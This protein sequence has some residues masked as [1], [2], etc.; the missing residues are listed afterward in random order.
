MVTLQ[1]PAR[2]CFFGDHQ[3]YLGLPVIAGTIDRFIQL[4]AVPN[5]THNFIIAL[6]DINNTVT[7]ALDESLE[8]IKEGDYF[9][10]AMAV[11]KEYGFRFNQG[12]T[13]TIRGNIPINAG[14]SS[15]SALTV[16]WIRFLIASQEGIKQVNDEEIGRWAYSAEV[17]YF[18]QPGGLMDH[19]T[20]AQRGLLYI[21]TQTGSTERLKNRLGQLV[22]AESGIPKRTLSV[23]KNAR[24]FA[25]NA[26]TAVRKAHPEFALL[27]ATEDDY[28]S[29]KDLVDPRYH[30]HWYAAIHNYEITKQAKASLT[31][32]TDSCKELGLLMDQHQ[33]ILQNQIQN[34]PQPMIAMMDAARKAGALGA[35]T[36]G[37]GGGGCM[38]AM[39]NEDKKDQV[40]AAFLK[41][42]ATKAYEVNL[43][44]A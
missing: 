37:S 15:S 14:L 17:E 10:S 1:V 34:T 23:L 3:D 32:T 31:K 44:G 11:V 20:I 2:I 7:I 4:L 28:L 39:V 33:H 5:T 41:S 16:A 35:K 21:D 42:G 18:D 22:V 30:H 25:Q 24:I 29:Y 27:S 19:F 43:I 13:I 8:N 38:V 26:V 12:H 40:I 9:R 6:E 36:V